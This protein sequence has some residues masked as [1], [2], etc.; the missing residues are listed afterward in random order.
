[1]STGGKLLVDSTPSAVSVGFFASSF[2]FAVLAFADFRL[3][4]LLIQLFFNRNAL[5]DTCI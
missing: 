2:A 3:G 5:E 1:M 4:I